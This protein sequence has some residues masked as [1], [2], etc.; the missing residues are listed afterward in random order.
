MGEQVSK[1]EIYCSC[2]K[3]ARVLG[4]AIPY[5]TNAEDIKG[6]SIPM[7]GGGI[8]F[9]YPLSSHIAVIKKFLELGFLVAEGN[10]KPCQYSERFVPYNDSFIVGFTKKQDISISDRFFSQK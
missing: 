6:N 8:V 2:I 5:G 9:K 1:N 10:A 4:L 3:T 7:I